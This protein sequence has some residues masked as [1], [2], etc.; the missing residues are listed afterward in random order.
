M[1][2]ELISVIIPCYNLAGYVE[3]CMDSILGQTY[4]NLEII[5]IDDGSTDETPEILAGYA[6]KDQ[7]VVLIHQENAGAGRAMNRGIESARGEFL[8]FVDND[9]WVEQDMYEKLHTA[10]ITNN[11]DMSVCNFNLAY[12]DHIDFC[13]SHMCDETVDIA[14]NVFNYYCCHCACPKPNNYVWTRLYRANVIKESDVRFEEF[15]LGADT[16]F[17]FKLFPYI[18]RVTFIKE[19]LYYY[20]QRNG[21]SVYTAAKK[22]NIAK[23][24]ADGFEA[25]ADYYASKGLEEFCSILPMHAY[26][27]MRS[28]FFYSRL[29]GMSDEEIKASIEKGFQ[30]RKIADY[31]TGAAI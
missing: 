5:A 26:T 12:D 25:L 16:L 4:R 13:Y 27:R 17:N 20:V 19:G 31:L 2:N 7:R 14:D 24:Y 11:A 30:G 28:T 3:K 10:L 1:S 6:E 9:D 8:A 23:V 15:R 29:A 22:G 21:S 18:K